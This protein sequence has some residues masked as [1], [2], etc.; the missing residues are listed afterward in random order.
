MSGIS[1]KSAGSL[2]NRKKYNGKE[3]QRQEFSDGSGLEWLDYGARMYDNQ[4]GRWHVIDPLSE[5]TRRWSTYV[6]SANNPLR[7][8]DPDGMTWEDQKEADKLKLAN[9]QKKKELS[10]TLAANKTTLEDTNNRL[11]KRETKKLKADNKDLSDRINS[12]DQTIKNIDKLGNDDHMYRLNQINSE[13]NKS[14]VTSVKNSNGDEIISINAWSIATF[15]HEIQHVTNSLNSGRGLKFDVDNKELR[16]S[17]G[18]LGEMDEVTGYRAQYAFDQNS[19][20]GAYPKSMAG[21]N[22]E[23]VAFLTLK[24]GI[25]PMYRGVYESY[26]RNK[27]KE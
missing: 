2:A 16:P 12:L 11:N 22:I 8:I 13:S 21:I 15:D 19:L 9:Q 25:T 24:D 23:Y 7:F 17:L 20:P 4:I 1:S 5:K 14:N 18:A 27:K 3:E 10:T 6:F 26:M